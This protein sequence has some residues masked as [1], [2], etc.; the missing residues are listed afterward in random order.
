MTEQRYHVTGM[1]CGHCADHI[2]KEV[3]QVAGVSRVDVDVAANAVT[4]SG[5]SLDDARIREAIVEAGYDVV[6]AA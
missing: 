6:A 4:V 3:G 2:R 5:P 1:T